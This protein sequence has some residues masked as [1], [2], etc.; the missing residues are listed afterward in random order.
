[1]KTC[2]IKGFSYMIDYSKNSIVAFDLR[3]EKFRVIGLGDDIY[4]N[5]FDYNLIEVKEKIALLDCWG[6]FTEWKS[7]GIHILT[8]WKDVE[9][10][11]KPKYD[12][13]QGFCDSRDGK[14]IFIATK[15]NI[16]FCYFY[17][18]KISWRYLEIHGT[19]V[20]DEINGINIYI[21]SLY[22]C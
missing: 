7:R 1:M 3:A 22:L 8:Q 17:D 16:L 19:S 13:P 15:N 2:S 14:I 18:G 20:E 6:S 9:D 12:P 4:K 11:L 10:I 21:E 5:L